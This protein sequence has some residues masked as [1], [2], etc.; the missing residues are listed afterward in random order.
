MLGKM[1]SRT[2][3]LPLRPCGLINRG[4]A[5]CASCESLIDCWHNRPGEVTILRVAAG[6]AH[7]AVVP[8]R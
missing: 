2:G 7:E 5:D 1:P 4:V 3:R 8:G 6:R